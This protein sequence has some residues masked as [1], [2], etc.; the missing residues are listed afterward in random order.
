[1]IQKKN[2]YQNYTNFNTLLKKFIL[3]LN[4]VLIFFI[5][6][7]YNFFMKKIAENCYQF[8]L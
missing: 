4:F 8:T 3:P 5:G 1:V 2:R 7:T 6:N